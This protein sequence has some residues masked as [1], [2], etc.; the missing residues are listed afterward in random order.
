VPLR[1]VSNL[2]NISIWEGPNDTW[3]GADY[4]TSAQAASNYF[5]SDL[6]TDVIQI[7]CNIMQGGHH[8]QYVPGFNDWAEALF[9][10]HPKGSTK[11]GSEAFTLPMPAPGGMGTVC[12]VGA[13]TTAF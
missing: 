12:E 5:T 9:Y 4:R 7:S 11:G 6:A 8:W 3:P 1:P 13:Y 2:I 10:S